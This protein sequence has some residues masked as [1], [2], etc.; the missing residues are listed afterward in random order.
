M[1]CRITII[2][3]VTY[4]NP[5]PLRGFITSLQT[6]ID[7]HWRAL[8]VLDEVHTS[9]RIEMKKHLDDERIS[10]MRLGDYA[11]GVP[12]KGVAFSRGLSKCNTEYAILTG[13]NAYCL[14]IMVSMLSGVLDENPDIVYYGGLRKG[15]CT[16]CFL[17]SFAIRVKILKDTGIP[18][19]NDG[20]KITEG[21]EKRI[22]VVRCN[23][24]IIG[25]AQPLIV[26][27]E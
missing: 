20:S 27:N 13:V 25:I 18:L 15:C 23:P 14:P 24:S 6:Q 3:C 9:A 16:R 1:G 17:G 21:I 11:S 19:C 2:G 22:Q 12:W 26:S 7:G 4:D 10:Y 5:L 8:F